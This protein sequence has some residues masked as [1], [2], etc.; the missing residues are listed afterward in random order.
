MTMNDYTVTWVIDAEEHTPTGAAEYAHKIMMDQSS[1]ATVFQVK[2]DT[3]GQ[4]FE[5]D[6]TYETCD[7][8]NQPRVHALVFFITFWV[9]DSNIGFTKQ[10]VV[11]RDWNKESRQDVVGAWAKR[12]GISRFVIN[13][14]WTIHDEVT[15]LP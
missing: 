4:V 3:T 11:Q 14:T 7:P 8:V 13:Q 6:L 2:D 12:N 9:N 5:V 1:I 15:V 10:L